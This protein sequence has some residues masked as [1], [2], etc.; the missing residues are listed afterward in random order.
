MVA[1]DERRP[2]PAILPR[3]LK[4]PDVSDLADRAGEGGEKSGRG[5]SGTGSRQ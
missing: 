4:R 5:M 3:T 1:L 2:I